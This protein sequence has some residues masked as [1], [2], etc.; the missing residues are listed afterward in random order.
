MTRTPAL[1]Y[2][3]WAIRIY[4]FVVIAWALLSWIP[5]PFIGTVR[6]VL[7]YAV[8]PVVN[9]FSFANFGGVSASAVIVVLI[10]YGLERLIFNKILK[11][12]PHLDTQELR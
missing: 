6:N 3:L 1:I 4:S 10:L 12:N 8:V 5:L 2:L 11:D 9:L 7:G